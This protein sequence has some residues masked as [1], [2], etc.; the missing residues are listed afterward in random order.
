MIRT[1][2]LPPAARTQIGWSPAEPLGPALV[3]ISFHWIRPLGRATHKWPGTPSVCI[4]WLPPPTLN[5]RVSSA[6]AN[7]ILLLVAAGTNTSLLRRR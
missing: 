6:E 3:L 7:A 4:G 2:R 5:G 1:T